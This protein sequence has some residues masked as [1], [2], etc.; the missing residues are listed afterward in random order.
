[1]TYIFCT[2]LYLRNKCTRIHIPRIQNKPYINIL[3]RIHC[4]RF[5]LHLA[6]LSNKKTTTAMTSAKNS[7]YR[8]QSFI[9][10]F[11][12]FFM[13]V[14][15]KCICFCPS[16]RH[17]EHRLPK[18]TID[19]LTFYSWYLFLSW[20]FHLFVAGFFKRLAGAVWRHW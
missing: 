17:T 11:I 8:W 14:S 4:I 15:F 2:W 1:M 18:T 19:G 6:T 20:I 16:Q 7:S 12:F 9:Y 3:L 5:S 10:F 13:Q